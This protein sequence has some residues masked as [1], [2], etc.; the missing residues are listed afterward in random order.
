MKF[1]RPFEAF[2][3]HDNRDNLVDDRRG[4]DGT[5]DDF[6]AF[7]SRAGQHRHGDTGKDQGHP[8]MGQQGEAQKI[9]KYVFFVSPIFFFLG[10]LGLVP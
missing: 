3:R 5:L 4:G 8:R 2:F 7:W 1:P 9:I 6:R 10:S